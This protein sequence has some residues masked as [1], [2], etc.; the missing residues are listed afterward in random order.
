MLAANLER[1]CREC[2]E[3]VAKQYQVLNSEVLPQLNAAG[4][5]LVRHN[6]RNE[7]QRAWG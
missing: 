7:A 4:V 3:L 6:D 5:H 1:I 2:H